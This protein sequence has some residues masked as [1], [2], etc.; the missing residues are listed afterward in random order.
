MNKDSVKKALLGAAI[1]VIPFSSIFVG[2]YLIYKALRKKGRP[3]QQQ[4][5]EEL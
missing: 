1:I 5:K 4:A 2:S 3:D